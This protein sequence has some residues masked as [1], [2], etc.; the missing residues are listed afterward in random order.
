MDSI[1]WYKLNCTCAKKIATH[2][3]DVLAFFCCLSDC[4]NS[5]QEP[6]PR[7]ETG[8]FGPL[9][10][11]GSF[12]GCVRQFQLANGPFLLIKPLAPSLGKKQKWERASFH[13]AQ[14]MSHQYLYKNIF[15]W[16]YLRRS[17]CIA[18]QSL[19]LYHHHHHQES[20][21]NR[22][23]QYPQSLPGS[24]SRTVMTWHLCCWNILEAGKMPNE[25][26][27]TRTLSK[28]EMLISEYHI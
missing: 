5:G 19:N 21:E 14:K 9:A 2:R 22:I 12:T 15:S 25:H 1:S 18:E 17:T 27:W 16:M 26:M 7:V 4:V 8:F 28:E 23:K 3:R 13:Y 20:I 10:V 6:N 24:Q 11:L